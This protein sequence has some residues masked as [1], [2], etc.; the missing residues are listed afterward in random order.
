MPAQQ[1]FIFASCLLR[2]HFPLVPKNSEMSRHNSHSYKI[3]KAGWLAACLDWASCFCLVKASKSNINQL[4]WPLPTTRLGS[5]GSALKRLH[6]RVKGPTQPQVALWGPQKNFLPSMIG[7]QHYTGLS[8]VVVGKHAS[9]CTI[10]AILLPEGSWRKLLSLLA[11]LSWK[12]QTLSLLAFLWSPCRRETMSSYC[13][14][15]AAG[16]TICKER[17]RT[18]KRSTICN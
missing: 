8:L 15:Q 2:S 16:H 7:M 11:F 9:G 3:S 12:Q 10:L 6:Q 4:T 1:N 18:N 5:I 14:R 13:H 17:R